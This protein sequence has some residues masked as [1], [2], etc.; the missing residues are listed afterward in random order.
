MQTLSKH[1]L[2][3]KQIKTVII[4]CRD[5]GVLQEAL[6]TALFILGNQKG[7]FKHGAFKRDAMDTMHGD[8]QR[9]AKADLNTPETFEDWY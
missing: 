6:N 4:N 3:I 9:K 1:K 5:V 7:C 2:K 8:P